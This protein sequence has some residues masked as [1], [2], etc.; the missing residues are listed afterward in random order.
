MLINSK[1]GDARVYFRTVIPFHIQQV[2]IQ[3]QMLLCETQARVGILFGKDTVY[4][5]GCWQDYP[6][7]LLYVKQYIV[8]LVLQ[9]EVR[10]LPNRT[11]QVTLQPRNTSTLFQTMLDF[12]GKTMM[13][14]DLFDKYSHFTL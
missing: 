11:S 2:A 1:N 5:L 4:Q 7:R 3:L 12:W 10:I 9:T 14:V 8:L 13:S 6:E